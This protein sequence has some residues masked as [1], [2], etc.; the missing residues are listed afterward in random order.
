MVESM[1]TMEAR[2]EALEGEISEV[3]STIVDVQK[4]MKES[5][6]SLIAMMEKCF[7]KSMVEEEGASMVANTTAVLQISPEKTKGS[8]SGGL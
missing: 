2:V 7:G 8:S 4:A 5:H 6:A 3:R 1:K